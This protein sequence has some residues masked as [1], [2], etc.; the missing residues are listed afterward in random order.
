MGEEAESAVR[1]SSNKSCQAIH[2]KGKRLTR[3]I[4]VGRKGKRYPKDRINCHRRGRGSELGPIK[5][6]H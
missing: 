6:V 4:N 3:E 1:K 5:E 2:Y